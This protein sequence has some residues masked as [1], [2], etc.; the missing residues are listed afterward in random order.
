MEPGSVQRDGTRVT[1]R[2][3]D[4]VQKIAVAY[5][6]SL[7]DLFKEGKGVVAQGK[8]ASD[9][10]FRADEVLAVVVPLEGAALSPSDLW[11]HC[12]DLLP[13]PMVPRFVSVEQA[14]PHN[15][16]LKIDRAALRSRG[17]P[18]TSWDAESRQPTTTEA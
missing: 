16:S 3:T 15:D 10:I 18:L 6:G 9:G 4:N 5:T 8:L 12:R 17:R 13:R 1:F 2:V 7:P 11:Q 14:L